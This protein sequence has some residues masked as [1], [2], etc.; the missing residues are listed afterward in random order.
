[1]PGSG[2]GSSAASIFAI[3]R[4][5]RRGTTSRSP[6]PPPPVTTPAGA[7]LTRNPSVFEAADGGGVRAYFLP[8]DDKATLYVYRIE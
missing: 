5:G 4:V 1:M 7:S 3:W 2:R 8:D 6:S